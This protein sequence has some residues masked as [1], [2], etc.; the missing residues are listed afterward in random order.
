M[1]KQQPLFEKRYKE[2]EWELADTAQQV[3]CVYKHYY[4]SA[5]S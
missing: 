3:A 4:P 2:I 1:K 5:E